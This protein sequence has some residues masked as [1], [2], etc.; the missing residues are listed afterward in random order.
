MLQAR[1][2]AFT[3]NLDIY[4]PINLD[5]IKQVELF[6]RD[7][8][9]I[10][11]N[12]DNANEIEYVG[13]QK[14]KKIILYLKD[15]HYDFIK[16]LPA[17][18][19]K[20]YYC[21]KCLKGYSNFENHACNEVCKKCKEKNCTQINNKKCE[22]CN[23]ICQSNECFINHRLKV[24]GHIPKC[25]NCGSFKLKSH[26]CEGK[27]CSFCKT[28]V[29]IDHKCYIL[30]E[31]QYIQRFNKQKKKCKGFIF[32]D[33]EAMQTNTGHVVNLVCAEKI[34]MECLNGSNKCSLNCGS[35]DWSTNNDFCEWLFGKNNEDFI[36]I[37][38]NMKSYDGY[39]I[40]NYIISNI[41][42]N[43]KLPEVLLS[44]SKILL[45]K[46]GKIIIKDSINFM[47]MA[48]SKLPKTFS[49]KE[50]K[51]GYFPHFFNSPENQNY[52]G[53]YPDLKFYGADLLNHKERENLILWHSKQNGIFDLQKELLDYCKSD[54]DILKQS[55]I[56]F[57]NLF[58]EITKRDESDKGVDPFVDSLT[59]ASACHLVYRRNFMP[60]NTIGLI[61]PMG[62]C[63]ESTSHK[64]IIWLKYISFKNKI[65]IQHARNGG[66][67]TINGLK[68][69]GWDEKNLTAYEFHGCIYH[70]CQKC[71]KPESFN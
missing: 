26:V 19:N 50:L 55:C 10:I 56:A 28:E 25:V 32:F 4:K 58:L 68:I 44:G 46:F 9:I 27:W 61:P 14:E 53:K 3:L 40:L 71:Y 22:F 47:P 24:C 38:H 41:L 34:C 5:D 48:L 1:E 51:K 39:F 65:H 16:S 62:Y 15:G 30:T 66:E 57:R 52:V 70:G 36:A 45:I 2:L 63:T 33:Y 18:L 6:L 67:K 13:P 23:V 54:V 12:G 43:E 35:F 59:L 42:P 60:E 31:D 7:Y 37:A 11:L 17:F 29:S 21:F 64:A 8:Q 20:K 69:D 49:L